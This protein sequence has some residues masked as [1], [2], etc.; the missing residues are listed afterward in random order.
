MVSPISCF[1]SWCKNWHVVFCIHADTPHS[2]DTSTFMQLSSQGQMLHRQWDL[3]AAIATASLIRVGPWNVIAIHHFPGN[4][5]CKPLQQQV[6][7]IH[8]TCG[9]VYRDPSPSCWDPRCVLHFIFQCCRPG[10]F[11]AFSYKH[12]R[13]CIV[14]S[15]NLIAHNSKII[16]DLIVR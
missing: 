15:Y 6:I 16:V 11:S 7:I 4:P 12:F 5:M 14:K 8:W 1:S 3:C 10:A 2:H 9:H 13:V